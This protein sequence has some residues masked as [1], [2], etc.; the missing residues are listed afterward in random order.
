[1]FYKAW[2]N[3]WHQLSSHILDVHFNGCRKKITLLFLK[4]KHWCLKEQCFFKGD[5]CQKM[6]K[7][8]NDE[9]YS[10][11]LNIVKDNVAAALKVML[12]NNCVLWYNQAINDVRQLNHSFVVVKQD[13]F[14]LIHIISCHVQSPK[15]GQN[16]C[17]HRYM[18]KVSVINFKHFCCFLVSRN[19]FNC[20]TTS[21]ESECLWNYR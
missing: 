14:F 1:M 2:P 7:S 11:Y 8:C 19:P 6:K 13:D 4:I 15:I 12:L 10:S 5:I 21:F 17:S 20:L 3:K 18:Y 16:N 9:C